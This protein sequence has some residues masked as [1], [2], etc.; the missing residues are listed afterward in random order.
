MANMEK[1]L[2]EMLYS[3]TDHFTFHFNPVLCPFIT[4]KVLALVYTTFY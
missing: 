4:D 1:Y 2:Y 3:L